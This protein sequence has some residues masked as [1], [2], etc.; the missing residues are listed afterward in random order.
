[1]RGPTKLLI[2]PDHAIGALDGV[3]GLLLVGELDEGVSLEH[4][5]TQHAPIRAEQIDQL[6]SSDDESIHIAGEHS[7]SENGIFK[8]CYRKESTTERKETTGVFFFIYYGKAYTP[9]GN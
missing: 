9:R 2:M 4:R 1:M 7:S 5:H 8:H 6:L 3:V